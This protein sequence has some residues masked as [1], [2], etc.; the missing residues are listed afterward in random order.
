MNDESQDPTVSSPDSSSP[1]STQS[2]DSRFV[3]GQLLTERYRIVGVLGKGGMGEVYRADDLKLGQPVALKFLPE[4][5]E[6]DASR[7]E[8]FLNEVRTARQVSHPNVCRVHDV[9]EAEG[10][11][12][13]SMEYV[14]G[15][16]LASLLR[17]IGRVPQDRAIEL[18]RQ[19]CA[20][21][22]AAHEQ[23]ILHRDLK[24]AN[25]M[26][27]G[28]GRARLT[29]FGLA[30]LAQHSG[31]TEVR[32]GTPAYMAPEQLAGKEV[33]VR[34]DIYALGLVLYELFSGRKAFEAETLEEIARQRLDS[35]PQSPSSYMDALDPAIERVILRCL[36]SD[37]AN[38][39]TSAL[40]VSAAL[41]GGDP[42]AA[43]LAA[44]ETP[45]P[46]LVA[47]AGE[48]ESMRPAVAFGVV[49]LG[50]I[51]LIATAAIQSR[52]SL[53][54][55][56][57]IQKTPEVLADRAG[58]LIKEVGYT[59]DA[60]TQPVDSAMGLMVWYDELIK[61]RDTDSSQ[62]RW[63]Q[64]RDR[65][66]V[67][68]FWYRQS[69][70]PFE[71]RSQGLDA[72][73]G[74]AVNLN[75]PFTST[76]G[77]VEILYDGAGRLRRFQCR[78]KRYS[79]GDAPDA[80]QNWTRLFELADLDP[81]RFETTQ[82]RY[83]RFFNSDQR[84]AWI[85]SRADQPD[86]EFRV[87][88]GVSEGRVTLFEVTRPAVIEGLAA[89]PVPF[90]LPTS[91][92]ILV[93]SFHVIIWVLIVL[94]IILAQRNWRGGRADRRGATRLWVFAM[95][96]G[97]MSWGLQSHRLYNMGG[98]FDLWGIVASALFWSALVW[99]LYLAVEPFGRRTW[100]TIFVASS[101]L[102]S[103]P[104]VNWRDPA[105]GRSVF[106]GSIA[107]II[108]CALLGPI[109]IWIRTLISGVP[110]IPTIPKWQI[111]VSQR[112]AVADVLSETRSSLILV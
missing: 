20:G 111:L 106:A 49:A 58:D 89:D 83:Q 67:I 99:V 87:E 107:G 8:R 65:P 64:L 12:F 85:G 44:G 17:R 15:E 43:A 35:Q 5:L 37:P 19:M 47:Q 108:T 63:E 79:S 41:P 52:F 59:Q 14:D 30:S 62:D 105:V 68:A 46:E 98:L 80:D 11:H 71:P 93:N 57:S 54:S 88:A 4:G 39:P 6:N 40:A 60:Y 91:E 94:S 112:R 76:A 26:I 75:N 77:E 2:S 81:N 82:P 53:T 3:P 1:P 31:G 72:F 34:S 90:N 28:R 102:L 10:Q 45:S 32:A 22:A 103:R 50:V 21:L 38:R 100:P 109:L 16:D 104:R 96:L 9:G 55:F 86:L 33:S 92:V 51:L 7:L 27:D 66:D 29:D 74:G 73:V 110:P 70:M 78:P 25:V 95:A 84:F 42:L 56:M 101:R 36:E 23:G 61:I 97:L 69:P 48:K 13:L 18:S 24:P